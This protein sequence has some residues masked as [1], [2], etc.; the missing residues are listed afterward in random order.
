MEWLAAS[1]IRVEPLGELQNDSESIAL[2]FDDGFRNFLQ[3]G[4]P[5]LEKYRLPATVFVVTGYCGRNNRWPDQNA[6]VPELELMNWAE[7]REVAAR[8]VEL[9]AHTVNHPDL[10]GIP[11][12][13]GFGELRDCKAAIE[14]QAGKLVRSFAYP[15]CACSPAVHQSV[16][17]QFQIACGTTLR[18]AGPESDPLD[19]PRSDAYYLRRMLWFEKLMTRQ[20]SR[21]IPT[22]RLLRRIRACLFR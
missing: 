9:G 18:F 6:A 19:L 5:I 17:S 21:Y 4:L 7:L 16:R 10:T 14:G 3:H 11:E 20:G 22:R 13:Q 12:Q 1:G 15:Y 2:T 8:G